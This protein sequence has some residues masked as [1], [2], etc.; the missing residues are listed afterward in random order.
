[1]VFHL[2][3]KIHG[4]GII[5]DTLFFFPGF[6]HRSSSSS[7][8]NC[9][10]VNAFLLR[11]YLPMYS[12]LKFAP[13]LWLRV[14]RSNLGETR[15]QLPHKRTTVSKPIQTRLNLSLFHPQRPVKFVRFDTR[16]NCVDRHKSIINSR[17]CTWSTH[18]KCFFGEMLAY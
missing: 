18:V 4:F 16:D 12:F 13:R 14:F 1:M 6:F 2:T 5:V 17:S 3:K 10:L 11:I 7:V 9:A 15:G 8:I